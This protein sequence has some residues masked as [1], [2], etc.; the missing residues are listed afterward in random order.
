MNLRRHPCFVRYEDFPVI[1][2]TSFPYSWY[3]TMEV[4]LKDEPNQYEATILEG[5]LGYP[6]IVFHEDD[7]PEIPNTC[8]VDLRLVFPWLLDELTNPQSGINRYYN[9]STFFD[10]CHYPKVGTTSVGHTLFMKV[11]AINYAVHAARE[12]S[13]VFWVDTDV[14][15]RKV[16]P[17]PVVSWL[18]EHDISYIPFYLDQFSELNLNGWPLQR[19]SRKVLME[20]DHWRLETGLFAFTVNDRTKQFTAKAVSMYR[21]GMVELAKA[22]FQGASFCL[23]QDRVRYNVFLNDIFVFSLLVQSDFRGDDSIFHVGLKHG[24][25]AMDELPAWGSWNAVWGNHMYEGVFPPIDAAYKHDIVSY[26]HIG[27]YIF[28][29]FGYHNRGALAVQFS[30]VANHVTNG[31]EWRKIRDPGDRTKSLSRFLGVDNLNY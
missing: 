26:F 28:H 25:F 9:L 19:S 27:E 11:L 13:V 7:M 5:T 15:V 8:L 16:M 2:I 18:M 6:L 21:G 3:H 14:T 17:Q 30:G 23:Q 10:P 24:M 4:Y 22:C 12:G 31:N 20:N 1:L 29:F